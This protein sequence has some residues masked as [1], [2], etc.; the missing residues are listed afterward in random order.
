[1]AVERR[2]SFLSDILAKVCLR[3]A[4]TVVLV[5]IGVEIL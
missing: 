2:G 4:H 1:V 3:V 5:S